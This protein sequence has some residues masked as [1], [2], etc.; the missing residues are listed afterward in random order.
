[1]EVFCIILWVKS[2]SLVTSFGPEALPLFNALVAYY[3]HY[4]S[5]F[6]GTSRLL[7]SG[8]PRGGSELPERYRLHETV[9]APSPVGKLPLSICEAEETRNLR[10][11]RCLRP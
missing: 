8:H 7:V 1:M 2:D 9:E 6:Y 4:F 10:S 5:P 3:R 11:N